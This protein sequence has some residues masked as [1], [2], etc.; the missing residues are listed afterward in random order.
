MRRGISAFFHLTSQFFIQSS[1]F[2]LIWYLEAEA[3]RK[4]DDDINAWAP[5]D[6]I[7]RIRLAIY[8]ARDENTQRMKVFFR[9]ITRF[10][11][12]IRFSAK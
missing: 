3:S 5:Q 9:L 8:A 6:L 1:N 4:I 2:F 12:E 10:T 11:S 7:R